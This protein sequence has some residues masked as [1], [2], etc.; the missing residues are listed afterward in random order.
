MNFDYIILGGGS[1]GATLASRLSE[2]SR[3]SVCL[4][5][6]G[7]QGDSLVVRM[8]AGTVVMMPGKGKINTNSLKAPYRAM[9]HHSTQEPQQQ[10][11]QFLTSIR[12]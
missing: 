1:A 6:A 2:D 8:P 9:P 7:G 10:E 3:I 5:E 4:L 12:V 11:R